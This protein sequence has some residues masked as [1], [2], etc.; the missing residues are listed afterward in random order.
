[1]AL[2]RGTGWKEKGKKIVS[3]V[4]WCVIFVKLLLCESEKSRV[5]GDLGMNYKNL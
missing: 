5:G 2:G 3:G 4:A 1:L